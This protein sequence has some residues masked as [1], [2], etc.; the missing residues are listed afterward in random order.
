M[1]ALRISRLK[2]EAELSHMRYHRHMNKV[3]VKKMALPLVPA[4]IFVL[5]SVVVS[6]AATPQMRTYV[7][8]TGSDNNPCSASSPCKT[9]QAALALTIVGGEIYVLNSA[10]YG[11]VTINKAVTIT[12]EGTIGGILA[13][14]GAGITIAAGANDVVN[15]RGL[16]IDGGNS[17]S[18]GIQFN[19]GQ[20][21][22]I[23]RCVIHNFTNSGINFSSSGISG[24]VVSAIVV[25]SNASN[26]ILI[27]SSGSGATGALNRVTASANG[28]GILANGG[29]VNVTIT[30]AVTSGNNYG[31][32]GVGAA[33]VMVR[34]ST[35]SNNAI[36]IAADQSAIVGV[37]Q[38]TITANG[39]GWQ[40]TNSGQVQDYGNNNL[41]GN[42]T[43]G[44][45]TSTV[46][47]K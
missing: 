16:D 36:G 2:A 14:S 42:T 39:T 23:E 27:S 30:E 26:G 11:P 21:L 15:L 28:V 7:S 41:G 10:N 40:A 17:A 19:S 32:G 1:S 12:S 44:T 25:S 29:S 18:N 38:S 8:G 37:S 45:A 34:N 5:A 13:T 6:H 9:F 4:I 24:L 31:I 20:S 47:L 22:N 46:A 3:E 43:D 33:A 35:V